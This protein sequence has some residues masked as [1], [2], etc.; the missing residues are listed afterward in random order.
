MGKK[1]IS[2]E[3][4]L[5]I[6]SY[7]ELKN[8]CEI[9]RRCEVSEKCVRTTLKN[10]KN[11][12]MMTDLPRSGRPVEINSRD[13]SIIFRES[14]KFPLDS[15]KSLSSKIKISSDRYVSMSTINKVLKKKN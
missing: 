14:R 9:A 1:S 12:G 3:I 15:L 6:I 2:L 5:K 8:N 11:F 10:Y 13:E 4:K 7:S